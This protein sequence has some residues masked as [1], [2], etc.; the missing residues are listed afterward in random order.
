M[1][2]VEALEWIV[3][4]LLPQVMRLG[5]VVRRCLRAEGVLRVF[6][7]K[8]WPGQTDGSCPDMVVMAHRR[9]V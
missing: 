3:A 2:F 8:Q 4:C 7:L 1:C 5:F 9:G 6:G